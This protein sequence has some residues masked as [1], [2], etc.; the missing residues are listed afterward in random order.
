MT[1]GHLSLHLQSSTDTQKRGIEEKKER[2][3]LQLGR[4]SGGFDKISKSNWQITL[5]CVMSTVDT[6]HA[7][8]VTFQVRQIEL[9]LGLIQGQISQK[10]F[11]L[12]FFF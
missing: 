6:A 7:P 12:K 1:P 3:K 2:E 8:I 9:F 11:C 5:K 4:R 10:G